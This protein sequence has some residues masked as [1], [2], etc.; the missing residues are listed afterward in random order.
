[1]GL[2]EEEER[3]R[4]DGEGGGGEVCRKRRR[5][6]EEEE[7]GLRVVGWRGVLCG[8]TKE[9]EGEAGRER[10]AWVHDAR[11][12][13]RRRSRACIIRGWGSAWPIAVDVPRRSMDGVEEGAG[14][15]QAEEVICGSWWSPCV[16]WWW[17]VGVQSA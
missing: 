2:E 7:G 12:R 3:R 11:R 4:R 14:G 13:T 17:L 1:L 15:G 8:R 9:A 6:E 10:K 16:L 5:G